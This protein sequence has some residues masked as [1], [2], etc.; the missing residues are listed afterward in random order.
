MMGTD[1]GEINP[2]WGQWVK[3]EKE[4]GGA[5]WGEKNE[6]KDGN[7]PKLALQ[8]FLGSSPCSEMLSQDHVYGL[9][10]FEAVHPCSLPWECAYEV[11]DGLNMLGLGS[12]TSRRCGPL[13]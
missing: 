8:P 12:G 7:K 4:G 3:E 11:C 6:N 2:D 10:Q 13:E 5:W 1:E 9:V